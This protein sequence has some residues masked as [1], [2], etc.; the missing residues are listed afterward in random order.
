MSPFFTPFYTLFLP[1]SAKIL[2]N[3]KWS[4]PLAALGHWPMDQALTITPRQV[5]EAATMIVNTARWRSE[6]GAAEVR[7]D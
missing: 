2:T 1:Y 4:T 3:C 5:E 7:L 6:F